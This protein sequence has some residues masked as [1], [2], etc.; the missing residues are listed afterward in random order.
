MS[1]G[2]RHGLG[3]LAGIASIPALGAL[4]IFGAHRILRQRNGI[5]VTYR[6]VGVGDGLIVLGLLLAGGLLVALLCGSRLSPLAS[7]IAGLPLLAYGGWWAVRPMKAMVNLA[8]VPGAK[9]ER[10]VDVQF[11]AQSGLLVVIGAALVFASFPPSRWRSRTAD[12]PRPYNGSAAAQRPV[13]SAWGAPPAEPPMEARHEAPPLYGR[14]DAP[15]PPSGPGVSPSGHGVSPSGPGVSASGPGVSP[16]GPAGPPAPG[17][18]GRHAAGGGQ[19]PK[20]GEWT[21]IY[22]GGSS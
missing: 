18:G 21:Q 16:S 13:H 17:G 19:D 8:H 4:L 1:N 9:G 7:L 15:A 2:A 5:S 12:E 22:G 6:D 11:V 20:G 10:G 3:V 14:H